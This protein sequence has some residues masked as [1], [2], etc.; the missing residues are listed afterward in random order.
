[1][2]KQVV[3]GTSKCWASR[4]FLIFRTPWPTCQDVLIVKGEPAGAPG[5]GVTL[6]FT[7]SRSVD[8]LVR[9]VQAAGGKVID[10]PVDRP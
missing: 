8:E 6:S 5:Q 2:W 7:W 9:Q 3:T 4:A 1:M 10:G